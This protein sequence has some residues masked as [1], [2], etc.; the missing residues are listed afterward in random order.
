[1]EDI[2][3]ELASNPR[4]KEQG[5]ERDAVHPPSTLEPDVSTACDS[6]HLFLCLFCI[7]VFILSPSLRVSNRKG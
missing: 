3:A 4:R 2:E 7:H 5:G 1:M 6:P